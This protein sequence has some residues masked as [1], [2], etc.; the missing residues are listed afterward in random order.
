[1]N[2]LKTSLGL[3]F[4]WDL[5]RWH[6]FFDWCDFFGFRGVFN[7]IGQREYGIGSRYDSWLYAVV[8]IVPLGIQGPRLGL[9]ES[10]SW[11]LFGMVYALGK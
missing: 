2:S 4:G 1:M 6:G 7:G 5:A 11:G 9:V 8:S 3:R 10:F